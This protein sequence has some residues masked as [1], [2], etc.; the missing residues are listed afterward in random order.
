[1]MTLFT[2][3]SNCPLSPLVALLVM[4]TRSPEP[5]V[6]YL[7]HASVWH[8]FESMET[9]MGGTRGLA[10]QNMI[11]ANQGSAS[12]HKGTA[13]NHQLRNNAVM[14][15]QSSS[16]HVGIANGVHQEGLQQGHN[17]G[18]QLLEDMPAV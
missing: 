12:G 4:G 17:L 2:E 9:N 13:V 1:M 15:Q 18:Q 8:H 5:Q 14:T 10:Q 11:C 6:S 3:A 7:L 16:S